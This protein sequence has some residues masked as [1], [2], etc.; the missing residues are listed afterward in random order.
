VKHVAHYLRDVCGCDV[1]H[2]KALT[3][4]QLLNIWRNSV[5]Q[6]THDVRG[7]CGCDVI[8]VEVLTVQ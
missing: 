8:H 1:I 4:Q 2:V 3:L 6:V 7:V 5:K